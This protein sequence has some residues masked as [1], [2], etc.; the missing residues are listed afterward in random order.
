MKNILLFCL[1]LLPACTKQVKRIEKKNEK[2]ILY[3]EK[4]LQE[5][6]T[7]IKNRY[8]DALELLEQKAKPNEIIVEL[9]AI[10]RRTANQNDAK[11]LSSWRSTLEKDA[12]Y[13]AGIAYNDQLEERQSRLEAKKLLADLNKLDK[14]SLLIPAATMEKRT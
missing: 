10:I 8:K 3:A 6:T 2:E 5:R 1:F 7:R 11:P 14:L 4:K 13:L 9:D 12:I